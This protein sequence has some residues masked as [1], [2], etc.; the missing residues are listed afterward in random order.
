MSETS[1]ENPREPPILYVKNELYLQD[2]VSKAK[3]RGNTDLAD[4]LTALANEYGRKYM[5]Q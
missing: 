4:S 5:R 3:A 1:K 2:L